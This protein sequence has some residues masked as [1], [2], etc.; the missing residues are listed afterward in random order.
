M[1]GLIRKII[2]T[3]NASRPLGPYNQAVQI[4]QTIYVSGCIGMDKDSSKLVS[5]GVAAEA[6]KA[7]KN[8]ENIL[9]AADSSLSKVIKSTV[10]L[11]DMNDFGAV[12]EVYKKYF[13]EPFPA[14]S[15]I[16]VAKLPGGAKM[17]I[18][19]VA[20]SGPLETISHL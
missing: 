19:V 18:E 7:I 2:S 6:E 3:P 10:F 17:E 4:G 20:V 9:L 1:A 14:R 12:N 8:L 16:Q 15:C 13:K 11:E 5:G